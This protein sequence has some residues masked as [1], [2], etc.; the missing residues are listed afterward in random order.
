MF[1]PENY[2]HSTIFLSKAL[3]PQ[4]GAPF[5]CPSFKDPADDKH[6]SLFRDKEESIYCVDDRREAMTR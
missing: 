4:S 2:F 3:S 6:S 1:V 5:L